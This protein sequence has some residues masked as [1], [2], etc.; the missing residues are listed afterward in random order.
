MELSTLKAINGI[1]WG[2]IAIILNL[3]VIYE[4][5]AQGSPAKGLILGC[6]LFTVGVATVWFTIHNHLNEVN[7]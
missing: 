5:N 3:G 7:K 4:W 2:I 6:I 1:F